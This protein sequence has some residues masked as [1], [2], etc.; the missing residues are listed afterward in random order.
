MT[1]ARRPAGWYTDPRDPWP[2][3]WWIH[4][5]RWWDGKSWSVFTASRRFA[6]VPVALIA[7][8]GTWIWTVDLVFSTILAHDVAAAPQ[9]NQQAWVLVSQS[10][11]LL[12]IAGALIAAAVTMLAKRRRYP[13]A[14][15]TVN[16]F[17]WL[18]VAVAV[19]VAPKAP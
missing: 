18:T 10:L 16:A 11:P 15:A 4:K 3:R 2:V 14:L 6:W 12:P 19:V 13:N 1:K 7:A 17:L 9:V 8:A 5:V